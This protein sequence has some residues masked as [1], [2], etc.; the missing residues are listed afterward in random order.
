MLTS[1]LA[2]GVLLLSY[3]LL[4]LYRKRGSGAQDMVTGLP[5]RDFFDLYLQQCVARASRH[6]EY[7]FAVLLIELRGFDETRRRLGRFAAEE[8]L[9]DFAERVSWCIRPTDVIA[10]LS[11]DNFAV[12]LDE[13][14][15][16]TDATRV[17]VRVQE[18]L[19][20]AMTL[21]A[22]SAP[23]RLSVGVTVSLPGAV[24]DAGVMLV[25]AESALERARSLDRP[26]VVF[27]PQLDERSLED[28]SLEGRLLKSLD[29]NELRMGYLPLVA[30]DTG[31][32]VGFSGLLQ[33]QQPNGLVTARNFIHIAES[34]REILRIGAWAV[35]EACNALAVFSELAGRPML[36]T[37]NVGELE[38][39]RGDVA[40]VV[41]RALA[42]HRHLAPFL[43]IEIPASA[44]TTLGSA[45]E[46]T[47][48]RL[49]A[50]GVGV[51]LDQVAAG[52]I[53]LR[54]ALELGVE[55]VRINLHAFGG[56]SSLHRGL[57]PLLAACRTFAGEIVVEGI[58]ND[59]TASMIAATQPPVIAQGFYFGAPRSLDAAAELAPT[60]DRLL[61]VHA[62][63]VP[64]VLPAQH[65]REP[66]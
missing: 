50:F 5:S 24:R 51:H 18:S 10:R 30:S 35:T 61:G 2:A 49:R 15:R 1:I 60:R 41:E 6:S 45:V 62:A 42:N 59:A 13:V 43:R 9:A 33:W 57:S 17:A 22:R 44:L 32:L 28:L 11:D 23:V 66:R 34:S 38:L 53:P 47:V 21:A 37:V 39:S 27:D 12:V 48:S 40:G 65:E 7:G 4:Y 14:A 58:E 3:A 54:R 46:A 29:R 16:V 8:V 52:G 56:D 63:A 20:E 64:V 26:Y 36:V 19:T 25:E 31:Q 55:G